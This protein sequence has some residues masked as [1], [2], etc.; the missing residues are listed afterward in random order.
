MTV[1]FALLEVFMRPSDSIASAEK[2]EY[3]LTSPP[4]AIC[5]AMAIPYPG[6]LVMYIERASRAIACVDGK[7][8]VAKC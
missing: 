7:P 1:H 6:R 8:T 4:M 3:P 2:R 5:G